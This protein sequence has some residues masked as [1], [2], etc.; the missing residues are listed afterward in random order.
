MYE[1][2]KGHAIVPTGR[3]VGDVDA[4]IMSCPVL[5]VS[6]ERKRDAMTEKWSI[7]RASRTRPDTRLPQSRAGGQELYLRSLDH[8]GKSSEAKDRK[9]PKKI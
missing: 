6:G 5:Y 4:R 1:S 9:S 8:L 7:R 2:A 3:E